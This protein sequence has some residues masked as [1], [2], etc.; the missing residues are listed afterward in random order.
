MKFKIIKEHIKD[1]VSVKYAEKGVWPHPW[2]SVPQGQIWRAK[3]GS[4]KGNTTVFSVFTCNS[5]ACEAQAVVNLD[6]VL[7][8]V[9]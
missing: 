4:K 1:C 8:D 6:M 5:T 2:C 9:K 3:D 7:K